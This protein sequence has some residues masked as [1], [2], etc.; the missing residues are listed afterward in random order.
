MILRLGLT[1]YPFFMMN[2]IF[3]NY[4][5]RKNSRNM[6]ASIHAICSVLFNGVYL[7]TGSNIIGS[8][9]LSLSLGYF[10]FDTYYILY[11]EKINFLR[12]MYLYHH[13]ASM[14]MITNSHLIPNTH[15][16]LFFGELSNLPSYVVYHYMHTESQDVCTQ[17]IV[18][19]FKNIQKNIYGIIRI[20]VMTTILI[21]MLRTLDF[22]NPEIFKIV[23]IT[24]PVY[25]MGLIW[26]FKL[27]FEK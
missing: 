13:F 7:L 21:N 12:S 2:K 11:F 4:L 8:L 19:M 27:V 1:F 20:P 23:T 18:K 24:S 15:Q 3:N 9:S 6:V 17:I 14:Y 26:S 22:S 10:A 25:F 16:L 5:N